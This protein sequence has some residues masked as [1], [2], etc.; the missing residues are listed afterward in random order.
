MIP[1]ISSIC[2]GPSGWCQL[3]RRWWKVTLKASGVLDADYP[4]CSGGL[5]RQVLEKMGLDQDETLGYIHSERPDYLTF[6]A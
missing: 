3:P 5:D 4:E 2:Y 1:L 6:E